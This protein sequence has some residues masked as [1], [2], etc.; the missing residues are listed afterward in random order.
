ML[1]K[2]MQNDGTYATKDIDDLWVSSVSSGP[3]ARWVLD[4]DEVQYV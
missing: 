1:S 3:M 4:I 2:P